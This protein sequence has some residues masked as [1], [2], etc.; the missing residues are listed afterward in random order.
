MSKEQKRD[1][2]VGLD[3]GTS[4]I[5]AIAAEMDDAG[6]PVVLGLGSH[7]F[8]EGA[9]REKGQAPRVRGLKK[10]VIVS[11]DATVEAISRAIAEVELMVGRKVEEVYAG[12]AGPHIKSLDATGMTVVREKEVTQQDVDRAIETANA[13]LISNDDRHLHTLIQEFI[14]DGQDGV[15]EPVGMYGRRLEVK[16]HLVTGAVTIVDNLIKCI[17]RCGLTPVDLVLQPLASGNAVLSDDEKDVGVCLVDIGGG[18]T[19]IAVFSQGAIRHTAILPIAGDQ[20]TAD[21][22]IAL[23]TSTQD[24]EDIKLHYGAALQDIAGPQEMIEVPGIGDRPASLMSRQQLAG[25]IQP[26][27]EEILNKVLEELS[28]KGFSRYLRAGVVLTGGAAQMPGMTQLG[29]EIFHN[30]VKVGFP[31]Y[32]GPLCDLIR[33]PRYS[34]AM[35]LVLEGLRQRQRGARVKGPQGFRQMMGSVRLWIARNF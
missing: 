21:I 13:S 24:A 34:T 9:D 3:I 8:E 29:E 17:N 20:I 19:D 35:G 11:I 18:T 33:N 6:R 23:R 2:V 10:G 15:K 32:D 31:H 4:K 14:V 22:G 1:M 5:V 27:V 26:R 7:H 16:A 25:F 30:T 28:R 12:I